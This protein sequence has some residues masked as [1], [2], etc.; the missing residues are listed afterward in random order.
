MAPLEAGSKLGLVPTEICQNLSLAMGV[1]QNTS[2]KQHA[3]TTPC[4]PT[5]VR[6]QD[7]QVTYK[8][9]QSLLGRAHHML[10]SASCSARCQLFCIAACSPVEDQASE[11]GKRCKNHHD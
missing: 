3:T 8:A 7:A 1:Q 5:L 9:K 4:R 2:S 10:R 11:R 6:R